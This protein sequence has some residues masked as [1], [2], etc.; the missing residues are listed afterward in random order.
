MTLPGK[1]IDLNHFKTDILANYIEEARLGFEYTRDGK[2]GLSNPKEFSHEKWT[3]WEDSIYNYFEPEK[4]IC[5]VPLSYIIRKDTTSPE[6]S[7]NRDVQIIYQASI[8]RNMF[9]RDSTK[10][11]DILKEITLGTDADTW[12]K[13]LKYGRN[14]MQELQAH[15]DVTTEGSRSK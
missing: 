2:G 5:G 15:Y 12:I 3:Q 13:G 8:V 6:D 4:N 1:I 14:A 10:V 11:L 9:I 7:E